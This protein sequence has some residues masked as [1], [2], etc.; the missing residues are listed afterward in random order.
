M[1]TLEQQPRFEPDPALEGALPQESEAPLPPMAE[2]LGS[3]VGVGVST[4][5]Q[6]ATKETTLER[7]SVQVGSAAGGGSWVEE[8]TTGRLDVIEVEVV[9][10]SSG[11]PSDLVEVA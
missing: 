8:T 1:A 9:S 11:E 2:M 7:S 3:A 10:I 6:G 4:G 5:A